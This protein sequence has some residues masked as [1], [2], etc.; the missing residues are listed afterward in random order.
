[1]GSGASAELA[2]E[3]GIVSAKCGVNGSTDIVLS[4]NYLTSYLSV[5][6]EHVGGDR[7]RAPRIY[8]LA[9]YL[10]MIV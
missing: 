9:Y 10:K 3:I 5:V 8:V 1:V 2:S 7:K 4:Q 6:S